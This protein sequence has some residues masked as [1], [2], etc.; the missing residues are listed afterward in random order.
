MTA[1]PKFAEVFHSD[2]RSRLR[3]DCESCFGLCCAALP[4]A[5]SSDFAMNKN[6]G[7]PCPNLQAD[8]RCGIHRSLR[9]QGFRGCTVYDCFGAGQHLSRHTFGGRDWRQA[10]ET[11]QAMFGVFPVMQQLH[12]L[13]WYLTEALNVPEARLIHE[14]LQEALEETMQLTQLTPEA[15]M[16]LEMPAYRAK[17]NVLLLQ[18]SE[19]M[20]SEGMKSLNG[21]VKHPKSVGR[22][23]DLI[24]AKLR[25]ADLRYANLRGAYLIAANLSGADLRGADLIGADLRD[26]DLSGADLTG[27]LFLTQFQINAAKGDA[28]TK[29]PPLL[30]R[31]AHWP[32][33]GN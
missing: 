18:T 10:P 22:G 25:G 31:P 3:A 28:H 20:R 15:L 9:Q 24:G 12:E 11:A 30:V 8:F 27:S 16:E 32:G 26:T 33:P 6:A 21:K 5:S 14:Q 4:F 13:L 23:A 17:V 2:N 29:I 19:M 7:Q 1:D